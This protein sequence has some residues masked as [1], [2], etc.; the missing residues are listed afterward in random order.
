MDDYARL[1]NDLERLCC[2]ETESKFFDMVT[3]SIGEILRGLRIAAQ[4]E[5]AQPAISTGLDDALQAELD[6]PPASILGK[7]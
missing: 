5:S 1:A 7:E 6:H 2:A 3:D 4:Q